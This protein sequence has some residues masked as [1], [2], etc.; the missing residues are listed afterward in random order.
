LETREHR[1]RIKPV[2][3]FLTIDQT[4]FTY[5]RNSAFDKSF[6]ASEHCVAVTG[7]R[8][9][10]EIG[11]LSAFKFSTQSIWN[12]CKGMGPVAST[13]INLFVNLG[14]VV[15]LSIF[16]LLYKQTMEGLVSVF[17]PPG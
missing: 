10:S 17:E 2:T 5:L 1:I 14:I 3:N 15:A 16:W 6:T 9:V 13:T 12:H 11:M 4:C 8:F 7:D